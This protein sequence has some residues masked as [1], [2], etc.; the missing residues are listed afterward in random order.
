MG[1]TED[2]IDS[3]EAWVFYK[4][5]EYWAD[6]TPI[7]QDD[8]PNA[9]VKI[10]YT[11][12][13]TDVYDYFRAVMA[14][15]ELS[16]RALELTGDALHMNA[17][18]YTVWQYRR[19]VLKHLGSNL[20]QELA[21]CREMIEMN[22]KNYQVWHHR[23]VIVGW[24][25]DAGKELRLTEMI[26]N[27]DA[28]NYHA[29]EH[30]QWVLRTFKLFDGE[31]DYVDRLLDEDARNNS[32][33]NQRH[34]AITQTTGFTPEVIEREVEYTKNAINKIVG[35]ESPWSY[36][37][38]VVQHCD[39]GLNSV[40]D[41]EKWCQDMYEAGQRSPHLLTFMIDLMEDK[42]ERDPSVR[43]QL[44]KRTLKMCESLATEHDKIRHEYWRYIE[45][46]LNHRF[47]A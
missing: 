30:R 36:L 32:A 19:K 46:N 33:W 3:K 13:F 22:P 1:S 29:W 39:G 9:V 8:G 11:D 6:V 4:D 27:Q 25:G 26:F 34:F 21:F 47:S 40:G 17:A 38:G 44:L 14:S 7:P 41:L 18:N 28:K 42:L 20:E 31:L 43:P 10:A 23:R 37:R 35:N 15:G 16:E 2:D 45:R 24:L 12:A 5:R